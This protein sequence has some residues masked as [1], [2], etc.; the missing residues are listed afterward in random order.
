M[1]PADD[2]GVNDAADLIER[3]SSLSAP[4]EPSGAGSPLSSHSHSAA[5]AAASL[6]PTASAAPYLVFAA[7][8]TPSLVPATSA[9]PAFASLAPAAPTFS[10]AAAAAPFP[11]LAAS[12]ASTPAFAAT[13]SPSLAPAASTAIAS[14]QVA[15]VTSTFASAALTAP[16]SALLLQSA[17]ALGYSSSTPAALAPATATSAPA[18]S[19][20]ALPF[21]PPH[22][23]PVLTLE[24]LSPPLN[25]SSSPATS[26]RSP[27]ADSS[28]GPESFVT[29]RA[30]HST[31]SQFTLEASPHTTPTPTASPAAALPVS[32]FRSAALALTPTPLPPQALTSAATALPAAAAVANASPSVFASQGAAPAPAVLTSSST[33]ST[34]TL[35]FPWPPSAPQPASAATA[36]PTAVT[37]VPPWPRFP[38]TL[39]GSL[40]STAVI[41]ASLPAI[42]LP[43][44]P[45]TQPTAA[46]FSSGSGGFSAPT[47]AVAAANVP[48][49]PPSD[50]PFAQ[51]SSLPAP[52]ASAPTR[53]RRHYKLSSAAQHQLL[54][55][56]DTENGLLQPLE[57]HACADLIGQLRA[58]VQSKFGG[59]P[60]S[61]GTA[62]M[63]LEISRHLPDA[64]GWPTTAGALSCFEAPAPPNALHPATDKAASL[65][66]VSTAPTLP[67]VTAYGGF[68]PISTPLVNPF[69]TPPTPS[70]FA[71][72]PPSNALNVTPARLFPGHNV[73]AGGGFPSR[74]AYTGAR[75]SSDSSASTTLLNSHFTSSAT[76][77]PHT[78][79]TRPSAV[80]MASLLASARE[81]RRVFAEGPQRRREGGRLA[82]ADG[83][84]AEFAAPLALAFEMDRYLQQRI[85]D[86]SEILEDDGQSRRRGVP[87]EHFEAAWE[88]SVLE[89]SAVV[90]EA[91]GRQQFDVDS[92][93][94]QNG[95]DCSVSMLSLLHDGGDPFQKQCAQASAV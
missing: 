91:S 37:P 55:L 8:A 90:A 54:L 22:P 30:D 48:A 93:I 58:G 84:D 3:L 9:V 66:T 80:P 23:G 56:N 10:H 52:S 34:S 72:P 36:A 64:H 21:V 76:P 27:L 43:A 59:E 73:S 92:T 60:L 38:I 15:P 47:L 39:S 13:A 24:L 89:L 69:A 53:P 2:L 20:G 44:P 28:V 33:L 63:A 7:S 17:S 1:P 18:S 88:A 81:V 46:L 40:P 68:P 95:G 87:E 19:A 11:V 67:R 61:D 31:R 75:S 65:T 49:W 82:A 79:V 70:P 12:A 85:L 35:A 62:L 4:L 94:S 16:A 26:F 41:D 25:L 5:L 32:G 86:A 57:A 6:V 42:P 29:A 45:T 51:P 83:V 50:H 14:A 78:P 77:P 74:G 71:A